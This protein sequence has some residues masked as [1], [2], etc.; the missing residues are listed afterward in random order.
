[1]R[2][3]FMITLAAEMP[4][5]HLHRRGNPISTEEEELETA[6]ISLMP[7]GYKSCEILSLLFTMV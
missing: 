2:M 5:N 3:T 6:S 7:A 1:M 4:V